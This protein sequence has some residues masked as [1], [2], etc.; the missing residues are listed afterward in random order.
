MIPGDVYRSPGIFLMTEEMKAVLP[1]I[2]SNGVPYLKMSSVGSQS[3][4][5]RVKE[6]KKERT[7][8]V[9]V[10]KR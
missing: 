1:V 7:G 2:A 10:I 6:E 3:T 8:L 5:G 4:S 9:Q